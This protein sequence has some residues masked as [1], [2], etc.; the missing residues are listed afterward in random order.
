MDSAEAIPVLG[1][2]LLGVALSAP[3]QM[4]VN[5]IWTA[6]VMRARAIWPPLQEAMTSCSEK[7]ELAED[8]DLCSPLAVYGAFSVGNVFQPS[9]AI[10]G[11]EVAQY[12]D[13]QY[14]SVA[15]AFTIGA[16]LG[17]V[18]IFFIGRP[19]DKLGP[20]WSLRQAFVVAHSR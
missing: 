3:G 8:S 13:A 17:G 10:S 12:L 19:I 11:R 1:A 9:L 4:S 2:A 6:A 5:G 15:F 7:F 18:V 20:R 16:L 14:T